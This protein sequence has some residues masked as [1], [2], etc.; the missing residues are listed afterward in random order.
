MSSRI[1]WCDETCNPLGWWCFGTGT[2]DNPKR[3][4]GCYAEAMAKRQ[5][6][7]CDL[8]NSFNVPH[9]HFEQLEKLSKWKKPRTIF[10]QSM[11]DLFHPEVKEEWL[12]HVLKFCNDNPQ[13]RYLFL[14]KNA[15]GIP[16]S[17]YIYSGHFGKHPDNFY[18]GISA[19]CQEML[20]KDFKHFVN[21]NGNTFL[22]LEP[23]LSP[24]DLTRVDLGDVIC[25]IAKGMSYSLGHGQHMPKPNWVIIGAITGREAK[26]HIPKKEWI[27]DIVTAC[28]EANV[29]VFLKDNL[30]PVTGLEY[31]KA[32]QN[33][34]W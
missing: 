24:I 3:C 26:N 20:Q 22:S 16:L 23:L 1:E 18:F 12:S 11:G 2:K 8:C 7:K 21:V 15:K 14:T 30:I 31:V 13:H 33:Y 17:S 34:P 29:P 4:K 32:H 27:E 9:T 10:M 5:L 6:N 25:D 19:N 28:R